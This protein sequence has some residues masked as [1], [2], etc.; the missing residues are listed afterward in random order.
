MVKKIKYKELLENYEELKKKYEKLE[1]E[2]NINLGDYRVIKA[3]SL[4][5]A[6]ET[7]FKNGKNKDG[8]NPMSRVYFHSIESVGDNLIEHC[9]L[10]TKE[11][12]SFNKLR[13]EVA[14]TKEEILKM[15]KK[16]NK[17]VE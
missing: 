16:I 1:N 13:K 9:I 12:K 14:K 8:W 4:N 6:I 5:W 11:K 15:I 7:K 3:D 17:E 10:N 2:K